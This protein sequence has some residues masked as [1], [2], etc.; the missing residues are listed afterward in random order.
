M[1]KDCAGWGMQCH[2]H[3]HAR[4]SSMGLG[5]ELCCQGINCGMK[6]LWIQRSCMC[7]KTWVQ[8][9][10]GAEES[11]HRSSGSCGAV[12][13]GGGCQQWEGAGFHLKEVHRAATGI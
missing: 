3:W 13:P 5:S 11:L 12:S 7:L 8:V 6:M 1:K 2:R 9:S 4:G 10:R